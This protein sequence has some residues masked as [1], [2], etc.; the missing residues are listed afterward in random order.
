[1]PST[2]QSNSGGR[3][4]YPSDEYKLLATKPDAVIRSLVR[5]L[6]RPERG[7]AYVEA[8]IQLA[9]DEDRDVRK[10]LIG[11]LNRRVQELEADAT[12]DGDGES[13]D[14]DD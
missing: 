7:R 10:D 6:R 14:G 5:G 1:M 11:M 12:G 2:H 4:D 13:A 9:D 3:T 8:E